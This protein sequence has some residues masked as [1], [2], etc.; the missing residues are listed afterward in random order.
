MKNMRKRLTIQ[1]ETIRVL[2]GELNSVLGGVITF[3]D[4]D[5]CTGGGGSSRCPTYMDPWGCPPPEQTQSCDP[6]CYTTSGILSV[7]GAC[8]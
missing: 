4:S 5:L 6:G 3:G 1:R 2:A 7:C 8:P